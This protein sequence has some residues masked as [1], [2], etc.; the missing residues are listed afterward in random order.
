MDY[1]SD[2]TQNLSYMGK[3]GSKIGCLLTRSKWWSHSAVRELLPMEAVELM[4]L[5]VM[6]H[7]IDGAGW[8]GP[9]QPG[10]WML[11]M[12]NMKH[13]AGNGMHCGSICAMLV[14][15]LGEAV[16]MRDPS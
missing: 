4:G 3:P 12:A 11:S 15:V 9:W 13:I 6:Q 8:Y 16:D 7:S 14:W 1:Y 5:P 2:L 10:V